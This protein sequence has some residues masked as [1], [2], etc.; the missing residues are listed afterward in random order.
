MNWFFPT[1]DHSSLQYEE[2][3]LVCHTIR[4]PGVFSSVGHQAYRGGKVVWDN[5]VNIPHGAE[6]G[7]LKLFL[8]L[9]AA[10]KIGQMKEYSYKE[11]FKSLL[12]FTGAWWSGDMELMATMQVILM[13]MLMLRRC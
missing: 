4:F 2:L 5:I 12:L 6:G 3:L 9:V 11:N 1:P 7:Y 8:N 10:P 13:L